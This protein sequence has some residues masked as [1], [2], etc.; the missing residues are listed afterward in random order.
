[1]IIEAVISPRGKN[2]EYNHCVLLREG[3][4][5]HFTANAVKCTFPPSTVMRI[6]RQVTLIN[7]RM[8]F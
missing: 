8:K 6:L 7:V 3:G 4:K 1:M 5:V 2:G